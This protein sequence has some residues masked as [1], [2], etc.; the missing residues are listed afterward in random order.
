MITSHLSAPATPAD[1]GEAFGAAH[2]DDVAGTIERYER[3]FAHLADGPFDL[4]PLGEEALRAIEDYAPDAATEIRGIAGGASVDP[5]A[6]AAINARTEILAGLGAP[7][8]GE[9]STIVVLGPAGKEPVSIQTWDW[10]DL[11]ADS[12]LVWSIEHP[13]GHLVHTV[14][15]Y[16]ILGKIGVSSRGFGIHFNILNHRSDRARIGVPLHVLSRTALDTATDAGSALALLGA[17]EVS[18]SSTLTVVG[19]SAA[20]KTALSAELT[21][22]GPRFVAPSQT[23]LLIHTNH[24]LD[25]L[26]AA[27]DLMPRVGPDSYV[28]HDVLNRALYGRTPLDRETLRTLMASHVGGAGAVC[29][30]PAAGAGLGECW[31]TL[32]TVALDVCGGDLWVRENGPCDEGAEWV[33]ADERAFGTAASAT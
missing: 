33:S 4:R 7:G 23:G 16:G 20:G 1:R 14:T 9:C 32:A 28:R 24:F 8:R 13:D 18:A 21:P 10:H 30:H 19:A 5:W 31:Q 22:E 12:W 26:L 11:F 17:A 27:G 15:E 29:C 25:P 6:V 3:L 2:A